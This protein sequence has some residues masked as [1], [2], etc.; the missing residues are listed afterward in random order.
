MRALT[1]L[2]PRTGLWGEIITN[3]RSIPSIV[4]RRVS[5]SCWGADERVT[6]QFV[7]T[8]AGIKAEMHLK[9][10]AAECLECFTVPSS[11]LPCY[12]ESEMKHTQMDGGGVERA[13]H[14]HVRLSEDV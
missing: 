8:G 6:M 9:V 14:A 2:T 7:I 3:R 10:C 11:S 1:H 12:L 5:L 4:L 13:G